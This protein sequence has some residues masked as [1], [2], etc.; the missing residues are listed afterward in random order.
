MLNFSELFVL[1]DTI[2]VRQI[3][4]RNQ[5]TYKPL[6]TTY[7]ISPPASF[8]QTSIHMSENIDVDIFLFLHPV[9]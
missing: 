9:L 1:S 6:F 5:K 2:G 3:F 8:V 7:P 4:C